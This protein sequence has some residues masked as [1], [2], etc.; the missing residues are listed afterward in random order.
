[1][2]GGEE[3]SEP[4]NTSF[5]NWRPRGDGQEWSRDI[6]SSFG[7]SQKNLFRGAR[8]QGSKATGGR[9]CPAHTGAE[10]PPQPPKAPPQGWGP[11][12][13][14]VGRSYAHH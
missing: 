3:S 13:D 7:M 12:R 10:S 2:R 11:R 9:R 6:R 4:S 8:L 1:M 14:T 5:A